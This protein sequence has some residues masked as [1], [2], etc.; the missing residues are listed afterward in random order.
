MILTNVRHW[1]KA[2]MPVAPRFGVKR[3]SVEY[4]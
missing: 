1:H 4:H 3:T 2:D